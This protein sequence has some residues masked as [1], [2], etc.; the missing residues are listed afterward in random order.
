[1]PLTLQTPAACTCPL[2]ELIGLDRE[3]KVK[4]APIGWSDDMLLARL[5]SRIIRGLREP[6][7][8]ARASRKKLEL[9]QKAG[10]D[11]RAESWR[12]IVA[13]A[14]QRQGIKVWL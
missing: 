7:S 6:W 11:E 4:G 14:A 5:R 9:R 8:K 13:D 12:G 3:A 2:V 1:M 10:G